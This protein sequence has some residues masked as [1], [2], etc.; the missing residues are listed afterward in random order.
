MNNLT[1]NERPRVIFG[2]VSY[3]L[4]PNISCQ[5]LI[6]LMTH[7]KICECLVEVGRRKKRKR[8]ENI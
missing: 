6:K 4:T 2:L 1:I 3:F 8:K 7:E 5:S